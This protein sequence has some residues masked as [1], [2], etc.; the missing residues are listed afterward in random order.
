MDKAVIIIIIIIVLVGVGFWAWQS[1]IFSKVTVQPTPLPPGIVLFYGDGCPHCKDVE[2]FISQNKIE[3]KV[4]ITRLEV[5]YNKSN[6]LLLGQIAQKCGVAGD[7]VG[8]PFLYDPPS[9]EAG[10]NGAC[11]IGEIDV[12]NFLK[13]AAGIK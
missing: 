13:N 4:K 10:G 11:Y 7:S 3:D 9:V 5:W 12:P 2:D 8:V 6:V 1:G